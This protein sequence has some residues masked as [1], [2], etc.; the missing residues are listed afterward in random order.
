MSTYIILYDFISVIVALS[1][2]VVFL[3]TFHIVFPE[4]RSLIFRLKFKELKYLFEQ[5]PIRGGF[6][7]VSFLIFFG[8]VSSYLVPVEITGLFLIRTLLIR[9]PMLAASGVILWVVIHIQHGDWDINSRYRTI[10]K[11]DDVRPLENKR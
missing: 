8:M 3:F 10:K 7:A 6:T 1:T 2:L 11:E 4:G 9:L 5:K